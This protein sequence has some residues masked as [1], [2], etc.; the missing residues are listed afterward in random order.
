MALIELAEQPSFECSELIICIDRFIASPDVEGI[1]R[2]LGW[3]GFELITL[4]PWNNG[5]ED[6]STEWLMLAMEV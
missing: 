1:V 2:D 4:A 5:E 6:S 3:V